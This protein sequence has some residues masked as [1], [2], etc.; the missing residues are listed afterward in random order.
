SND[1]QLDSVIYKSQTGV[2]LH[3][4]RNDWI[5]NLYLLWG[6]SHFFQKEFD[7]AAMMFQFINYAFAERDEDGYYKHIGSR[8]EG[9]NSFTI[10]TKENKK[11]LSTSPSRND[12]LVWLIRSHI[13]LDNMAEAGSLIS[14]LRDDPNFPKRLHPALEEVQALWF[15]R[16]SMWDSSAV[17][18]LNALDQAKTKQERAR[19]EYLAAQMF[20]KSRNYTEAQKYFARSI[21]HTTDPVLEVYARLNLVRINKE[22]GEN[23]IDKNIA[24]LLK[25]AKRDKYADYR[26]VIYFMAA[27]IELERGNI[28][29]ANDLL[30]KGAKYNTN[31]LNSRSR[32]YL[33]IAHLSFKQKKFEQAARFYD[34]VNV[35]DIEPVDAAL[36]NQRKPVLA[37]LV[38][39]EAVIARQDSLQRIAALPEEER[40]ALI[41]KIVKQLRRQQGLKDDNLPTG[42]SGAVPGPG[43][44]LFENRQR[45]EWYFYN[46]TLKTS[47]AAQFKQT[48]GTR[49]NVDNWRRFSDVS[50]Q[51]VKN[52]PE[53]TRD[54]V[55][56]AAAADPSDNASAYQSLLNNLPLTPEG[57]QA[58]N[59]SIRNAIYGLGMIFLNDLEEYAAAIEAF[60]GLRLRFPDDPKMDEVLFNLYYAYT[61]AG[62]AAKAAQVKKLLSEKYNSSRYATIVTTGNDPSSPATKNTAATKDYEAI[63]DM[64]VEGRFD[65]ARAAK[66]IADSVHHTSAW[67]PQLLYIEAVYLVRQRE[68]SLAKTALQTLIAQDPN[69]PLAAKAQNLL[70]VLNRRHEIEAELNSLNIERPK[71]DTLAATGPVSA[72]VTTPGSTVRPPLTQAPVKD[73]L[74]PPSGRDSSSQKPVVTQQPKAVDTAGRKPVTPS[75]SL[76][77]FTFQPSIPHYAVLVLNTVDVVFGNEAKNAFSRYN[78]EKYAGQ[79]LDLQIVN[80]DDKNKLLL[81][82]VLPGAQAAIDYAQTARSVAATQ[83][84]PWLKPERYSFAIISP[85]NLEVL[86]AKPDLTEYRRFLEQNLPGKF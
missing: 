55:K 78:R 57:M 75:Q 79:A 33:Q 13:E 61:K 43:A 52:L 46:S 28:A 44:N 41:N 56:N 59:D 11:F 18:L 4:L 16:Q 76:S 1:V 36:V 53:N 25:M 22:G 65:E 17:H 39:H 64:F 9:Q 71:E 14:T 47:G 37:R 12:A 19:W 48:W 66:K 73:T 38:A 6:A 23:Y 60:E 34:S 50:T 20:E 69:A 24:E 35:Q 62:D 80:L 49:P 40:D 30:L 83:I 81:I 29:A 42:G 54:A 51:M 86:K 32:V 26:D 77:G 10:A 58:S 8:V 27:Q 84:I 7:S 5:D 82:G 68:D 70:Q 2:V 45:G 31:N 72:P 67:Q 15:Y 3:D 63:Y 74:L 21:S 85:Q